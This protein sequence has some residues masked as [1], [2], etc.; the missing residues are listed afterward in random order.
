MRFLNA[1]Y[2]MGLVSKDFTMVARELLDRIKRK[3]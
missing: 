3:T 2:R 1:L